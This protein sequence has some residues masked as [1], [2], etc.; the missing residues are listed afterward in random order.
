MKLINMAP[1][2]EPMKLDLLEILNTKVPVKW[3]SSGHEN[4]GEFEIDGVK[5]QIQANEFVGLGS[6]D[7][8]DVGFT[9]EGLTK[10]VESDKPSARIVGAVFNALIDKL[11]ELKPDVILMSV[12]KTSGLIE[13]R[14]SIYDI[15]IRWTL[16]R[17]GFNY[18]GEW[19]ENNDAFYKIS[20]K[21]KPSDEQINQFISSVKSK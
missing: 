12:Q 11:L 4:S 19:I 20:G 8:V 21:D 14:K 5:F 7:V 17:L 1:V 9:R 6:L 3:T 2:K 18:S 13:S 10:A 15:M 16:R